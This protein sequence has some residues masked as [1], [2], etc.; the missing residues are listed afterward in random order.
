MNS[1]DER[2]AELRSEYTKGRDHLELLQR[3]QGEIRDVVLRISGAI[4]VLEDLMSSH[5]DAP[6]PVAG[7]GIRERLEQ[8]RDERERGERQLEQVERH[9]AELR[10]TLLRISGAIQVLEEL[11]TLHEEASAVAS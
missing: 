11:E 4:Q 2:L 10:D 7:A 8:L 6:A 5:P 3:R 9:R 1:P